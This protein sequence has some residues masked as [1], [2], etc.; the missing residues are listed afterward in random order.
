MTVKGTLSG[1][2]TVTG[3]LALATDAVIEI[4]VEANNTIQP[5]TIAGTVDLSNGGIVRLVGDARRLRGDYVLVSCP[6]LTAASAGTWRV[7]FAGARDSACKYV[8]FASDGAFVLR[9]LPPGIVM[10]FR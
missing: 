6:S 4:A 8:A 5:V 9:V 1:G 2:G 7:E 3:A 10:S